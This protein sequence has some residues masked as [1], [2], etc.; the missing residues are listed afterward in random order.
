MERGDILKAMTASS[1]DFIEES[2]AELLVPRK[3]TQ[4]QCN[5]LRGAQWASAGAIPLVGL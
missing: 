4:R 3:V 5:E 2:V 1:T